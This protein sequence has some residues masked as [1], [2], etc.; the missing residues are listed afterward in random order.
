MALDHNAAKNY[1]SVQSN[2]WNYKG[3]TSGSKI[4]DDFQDS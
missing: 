2:Y 1:C 4:L 3:N